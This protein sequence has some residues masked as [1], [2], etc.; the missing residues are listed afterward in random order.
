MKESPEERAARWINYDRRI[1]GGPA[2][3]SIILRIQDYQNY[4]NK[5]NFLTAIG[6]LTMWLSNLKNDDRSKLGLQ[7]ACGLNT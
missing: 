4:E 2:S 3:G 6:N 1:Q 5:I 7:S